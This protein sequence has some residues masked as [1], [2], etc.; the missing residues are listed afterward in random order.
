MGTHP[1]F[2]SDFDCLTDEDFRTLKISQD[3]VR[4]FFT[5]GGV[6][7]V[8]A[9]KKPMAIVNVIDLS[10]V[11]VDDGNCQRTTVNIK[12]IK[13]T[14]LKVNI[15]QG[16]RP[17]TVRKAWAAAGINDAWASTPIALA[18]AK[19]A[20]RASLS[21][22]DRFKLMRMKQERGRIVKRELGKLKGKK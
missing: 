16:A 17:G 7:F 2:E 22:F 6:V 8:P 1:I 14:D 9:L 18:L 11:L 3:G 4:K 10:R 15:T 13:L 20:K 21:D 5:I 12:A 19:S